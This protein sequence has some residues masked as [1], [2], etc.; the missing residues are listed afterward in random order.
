MSCRYSHS[1]NGSNNGRPNLMLA[2]VGGREAAVAEHRAFAG[3]RRP[4]GCDSQSSRAC[5]SGRRLPRAAL[6]G[7]PFVVEARA[8]NLPQLAV[9]RWSHDERLHGFL[10]IAF[11]RTRTA[12]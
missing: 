8:M 9:G 7:S 4:Q 3:L 1:R 12:R 5:G 2:Q 11:S 6:E 10:P